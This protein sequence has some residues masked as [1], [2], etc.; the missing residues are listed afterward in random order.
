[1]RLVWAGFC[2]SVVVLL[3]ASPAVGAAPTTSYLQLNGYSGAE[4]QVF[5]PDPNVVLFGTVGNFNNQQDLFISYL[6]FRTFDRWNI[7]LVPPSGTPLLPGTYANTGNFSTWETRGAIQVLHAGI[8]D[9]YGGSFTIHSLDASQNIFDV[10][11]T[12]ECLGVQV[13]GRAVFVAPPD[14]IPPRI[15]LPS[16]GRVFAAADD[17]QGAYVAYE[18]SAADAVDPS[19]LLE[20]APAS[21]SR[22]AIGE[23]WVTCT[24][25]DHSG[26][27]ATTSFPV[28]V[29]GADG[30]LAGLRDR[31]QA[32]QASAHQ[33]SVTVERA[34]RELERAEQA[35][36]C[37]TMTVFSLQVQAFKISAP[38]GP[39]L[40]EIA[41]R[42]RRVLGC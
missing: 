41:A 23:T 37:R 33:L 6:D 16:G 20:C 40:L 32:M 8:S 1:M 30:L 13:S 5:V 35:H 28:I 36:A 10:E 17:P 31:L 38:D 7:T 14:T 15:E 4:E 24:A 25:R 39:E 26:N 29:I 3:G 34:Q 42:I 21:G 22:F 12:Q 18:V 9:C 27:A 2:A 11:W 19:P